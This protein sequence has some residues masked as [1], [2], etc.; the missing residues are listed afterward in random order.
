MG[1]DELPIPFPELQTR[2]IWLTGVF[3]YTG[4]WPIAISMVARHQVDLT[5]M[6]TARYDLAH[7]QDALEATRDPHSIKP[8]VTL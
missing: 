1:A 7:V 2:E 3:R 4:T 5:S 8:M 6:V